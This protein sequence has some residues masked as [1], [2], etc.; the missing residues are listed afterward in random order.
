MK[1]GKRKRNDFTNFKF[2]KKLSVIKCL[3][4]FERERAVASVV[5]K[6]QHSFHCKSRTNFPRL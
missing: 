2:F 6:D 1:G 3:T 4:Y 5:N